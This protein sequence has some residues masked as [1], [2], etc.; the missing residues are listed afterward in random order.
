MRYNRF[1]SEMKPIMADPV[2]LIVNFFST[3][4]KRERA[5][6]KGGFFTWR[7]KIHLQK[8]RSP[9][10]KRRG[11]AGHNKRQCGRIFASRQRRHYG[12]RSR[13]MRFSRGGG[14]GFPAE[15]VIRICG[16]PLSVPA[17]RGGKHQ[18][19]RIME[20]KASIGERGRNLPKDPARAKLLMTMK[21]SM[22]CFRAMDVHGPVAGTPKRKTGQGP[23]RRPYSFQ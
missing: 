5:S 6:R 22:L 15:P 17:G 18:A 12:C 3:C 2:S 20:G 14:E 21:E 11:A 23:F 16:S 9:W 19:G 13:F 1:V 4:Q 10:I 7:K 8:E